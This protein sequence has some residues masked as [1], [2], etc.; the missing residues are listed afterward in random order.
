MFLLW[1]YWILSL[2]FYCILL[3]YLY[4]IL[5]L[6]FYCI[7]CCIII[8]FFCIISPDLMS[9]TPFWQLHAGRFLLLFYYCCIVVVFLLYFV[10]VSYFVIVFFCIISLRSH[11]SHALLTITCWWVSRNYFGTLQLCNFNMFTI[12]NSAPHARWNKHQVFLKGIIS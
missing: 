1:F 5:L 11:V 2:Y 12:N 8:V 7:F 3:L 4:Y 6:Y 10:V 9:V